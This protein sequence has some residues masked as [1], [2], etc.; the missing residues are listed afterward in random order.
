V[1]FSGLYYLVVL[2]FVGL[3]FAL[4]FSAKLRNNSVLQ[5][6]AAG[7]SLSLPAFVATLVTVWYGGIL[8]IAESV[9]Y[10]GVGTWLLLGVPYYVFA[11]VYAVFFAKRVRGAEQISIPERLALRWGKA[12]GVAGALILFCLAVP[13]AHSL[14][15]GSLLQSFTGWN[16]TPSVIVATLVGSVF[17]YKGGLLADVRVGMLAFVMMYVGFV[18][19]DLYCLITHPLP[20]VL[21]ALKEQGMLNVTGG[22]GWVVVAT[23][24]ILGAWTLVDPAF[25]QRVASSKSPEIG[26]RGVFVS[27]GFWFLF[28]ILSITAALYALALA[29]PRPEDPKLLYPAFGSQ[30][31]PP[32]LRAVF[33]CG[34]LGTIL[35]AMVGYSLVSGATIGR[36]VVARLN[37]EIDEGRVT[38]FTRIGIFASGV[39]A[40][41][42]AINIK[43]VVD[44]WYSWSGCVVGALLI[45]TALAYL[46]EKRLAV[47]A[48]WILAAMV[49]SFGASFW[50]L[51]HGLQT[52]NPYLNVALIRS[53]QGWSIR[54][55]AAESPSP[56]RTDVQIGTLAPALVIS[57]AVIA[58]GGLASRSKKDNG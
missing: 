25:H 6:L 40:I 38:L 15:L 58:L 34:M 42:L 48:P 31:L 9:S 53:E 57:G 56:G 21:P 11:I 14:M 4:G 18:V 44:L 22:S 24:F 27:V 33:F 43:S 54:A 1:S 19:I 10:Y 13:A 3:I 55:E 29:H 47:T 16:L 51:V 5:F 46:R 20:T 35:S 36:E 7:R 41:V 49:L 17:L 37:P 32:G 30:V 12:V 26:R 8:G 28:D 52:N 39:V 23:F 2:L 50:W 45:P